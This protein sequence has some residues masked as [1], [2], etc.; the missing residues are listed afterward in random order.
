MENIDKTY[1]DNHLGVEK[2]QNTSTRF[3]V[4]YYHLLF[5]FIMVVAFSLIFIPVVFVIDTISLTS[6]AYIIFYILIFF[7][8]LYYFI[9]K[10]ASKWE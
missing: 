1:D 3:D 6:F 10:G 9:K 7:A 2:S 8:A 5:L 4:R